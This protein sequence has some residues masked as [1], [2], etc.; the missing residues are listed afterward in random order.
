MSVSAGTA[1]VLWNDE[2]TGLTLIVYTYL[3]S[4]GFV[5]PAERQTTTIPISETYPTGQFQES[6]ADWHSR[7]L[8]DKKVSYGIASSIIDAL[9]QAGMNTE[10]AA[11]TSSLINSIDSRLAIWDGLTGTVL[12]SA[13]IAVADM[14]LIGDSTEFTIHA[15]ATDT[16]ATHVLSTYSAGRYLIRLQC[17]ALCR[18]F[19]LHTLNINGSSVPYAVS[20]I[21]GDFIPHTLTVAIETTNVTVKITNTGSSDL[22]CRIKRDGIYSRA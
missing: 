12:K 22:V 11:V 2:V 20:N 18:S 1:P 16:I 7:V 17:G 4:S 9:T 13:S 10:R 14:L 3:I 6:E 19:E 5:L 8:R 15:A 21:S